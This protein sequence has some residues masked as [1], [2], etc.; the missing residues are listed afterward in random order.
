MV[1]DNS[2]CGVGVAYDCKLGAIKFNVSYTTDLTEARGLGRLNNYI[3]VYSNSWGV[4]NIGFYVGGPGS[5]TKQALYN[6]AMR[7]RT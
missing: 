6:G 5:L 1:K 2:R 3:Q 4:R 7:V